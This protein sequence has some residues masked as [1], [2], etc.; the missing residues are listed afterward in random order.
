M[1]LNGLEGDEEK[2][3]RIARYKFEYEALIQDINRRNQQRKYVETR[4]RIWKQSMEKAQ[5][6][7]EEIEKEREELMQKMLDLGHAQ[8]KFNEENAVDVSR[9]ND[10]AVKEKYDDYFN[11][12][13]D[14]LGMSELDV[15]EL[16]VDELDAEELNGDER[17]GRATHSPT[18]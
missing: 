10:L 3:R 9:E 1:K 4:N 8:K 2:Q 18:R 5:A 7:V 11:L 13:T 12:E 17:D 15:E 16:S 14:E 6:R